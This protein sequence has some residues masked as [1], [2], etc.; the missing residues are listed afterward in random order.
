MGI[1]RV[2]SYVRKGKMVKSYSAKKKDKNNAFSAEMQKRKKLNSTGSLS[3]IPVSPD[4]EL[5]YS[6]ATP[7]AVKIKGKMYRVGQKFSVT[8]S[9][10]MG[11]LG[12]KDVKPG[13]FKKLITGMGNRFKKNIDTGRL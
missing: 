6:Y 9:K 8:T 10:H 2:K 1:K 13:R 5:Y 11:K 4:H 12:G 7:V 3:M